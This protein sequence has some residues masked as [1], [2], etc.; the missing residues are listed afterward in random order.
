MARHGP[1]ELVSAAPDPAW[2]RFLR[3][4]KDPLVYLLLAAIL[5]SMV[6]WVAEG[7]TG[8]PVDAVVIVV[9]VLTNAVIGFV[10]ENK[11]ADA[12]AALADMTAARCTVLRG[13]SLT[14]V[15]SSDIVPGDVLVLA[16]GDAVGADARLVSASSLKVQEAALTGESEAVSKGVDPLP[17]EVPLGDRINMV[18]KGR[19]WPAASVARW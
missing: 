4:F 3:Q 17:G 14:E 11:A 18:H 2:R 1:N 10:Q 16:E 5:I 19:R 7:A 12:V 6:A 15:A 8:V 9:I 13:G